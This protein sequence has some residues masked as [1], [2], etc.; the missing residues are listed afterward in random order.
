MGHIVGTLAAFLG[1]LV[2]DEVRAWLPW[3]TERVIRCA[4]GILQEDQRERYSEEWHSD[5]E[6]IPGELGRLI[7]A[8]GLLRAAYSVSN[9]RIVGRLLDR[10]AAL[11]LLFFFAPIMAVIALVIRMTSPGPV[12]LVERTTIGGKLLQN[13]RFR[14]F[15]CI[16]ARAMPYAVLHCHPRMTPVTEAERLQLAR[17]FGGRAPNPFGRF[18]VTAGI[19]HLPRLIN[20]LRGDVSIKSFFSDL[21]VVDARPR[22]KRAK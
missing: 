12:V 13:L 20:V 15:D 1:K 6:Q 3:T 17:L 9:F 4:V 10:L 11:L 8:I 22:R 21:F 16:S 14:T 2:A 19:D 7:W 5:I 18:L